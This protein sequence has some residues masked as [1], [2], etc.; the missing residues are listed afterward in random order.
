MKYYRMYGVPIAGPA[1]RQSWKKM[2]LEGGESSR[3]SMEAEMETPEDRPVCKNT[4][5]F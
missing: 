2:G 5:Y 4:D 1:E 3:N